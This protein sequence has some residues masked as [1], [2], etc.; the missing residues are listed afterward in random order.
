MRCRSRPPSS[1]AIGACR[2]ASTSSARRGWPR[3]SSTPGWAPTPRSGCTSTTRRSTA[4]SNFAAIKIGGVPINVN[5][6]YLDNE[7]VYLLDNADVEALVFHTSLGDRVARVRDR[8]PKLRL[9]VEVDDGPAPDGSTHLD[10]AAAYEELQA[11]L[12]PAARIEPH[13]DELYIFY[14]GGTTGMPK[15]VMYPLGEFTE[16]FLQSY[17]PM[18]GQPPITDPAEPVR[19]ARALF[20][21]ALAHG[22]H[23][24]AAAD[25]RHRVLARG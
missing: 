25:A 5:Y 22:R 20:E 24:G 11:T 1:R 23:V 8:L 21:S 10:G 7:L 4:R 16:F 6:R 18:I 14:T 13:G 9:L 2:G 3:R 15:G 17:P 19:Q 12:S